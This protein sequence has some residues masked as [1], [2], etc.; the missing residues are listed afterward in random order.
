MWGAGIL[1]FGILLGRGEGE[2]D[3]PLREQVQSLV[4]Q[5]DAPQLAARDAAE[6]KLL[7][8]GPK[9]LELLPPADERT[10]AEVVQRV[11]RIRQK[12][13]RS[14]AEAATQVSR[15]TLHAEAMELSKILGAF[16]EQTGNKIIDARAQ[17]GLP[18]ADPELKVDFEQT[19]FWQALDQVL[20]RARLTIYPFAEEKGIHVVVRP[21]GHRPRS[22]QACYCGPFRIEAVRI[23]AERNLRD[24]GKHALFVALEITWEPRLR[25]IY[26]EHAMSDV[27][28]VDDQ[29]N[30]LAVETQAAKLEV[31]IES[32][33]MA[34]ELRIPL[35][36]PPR[37]VRQ[38]ASLKGAFTAV[39]P[40]R[41]EI[42]R[43]GNL[44]DAKA[45]Q[46]RIAGATVTLDEVRKD[47]RIWEVRMRIRFDQPGEALQSHR[48][49]IF[50]NEAYLEDP[51][52]KRIEY[53]TFETTRQTKDE[54]GV[55]YLFRAGR[56]LAGHAFVYKTPGLILP[57]QF[58]YELRDL[59]LP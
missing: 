40:G 32:D 37:E 19:P 7:S 56:D 25:P 42:L 21:E 33:V 55:A 29:G 13:R 22:A 3:Q 35:A 31:P 6:E 20:D 59:K 4:R 53:G 18:V 10:P 41:V 2:I 34:K 26:L 39:V 8:L 57:I 49:W 5:L 23:T 46:Q 14:M 15:V 11:G 16:Q 36:L 45:V 17:S 44:G 9:V 58:H 51:N 28:A 48:T 24:P 54:L 38:I 30:P 43:F 1:I 47:S 27:S 50:E 52:K 12:L